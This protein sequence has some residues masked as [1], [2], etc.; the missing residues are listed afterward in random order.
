MNAKARRTT[1]SPQAPSCGKI[2]PANAQPTLTGKALEEFDHAF[3]RITAPVAAERLWDRVLTDRQRSR[4][5]RDVKHAYG[6]HQGIIGMWLALNRVTPQ[7]AT[8]DCALA[9]NFLDNPTHAWLRREIGKPVEAILHSDIP[10]WNKETGKL[11]F[12]GKRIRKVRVMAR[13]S[14]IQKILDKFESVSWAQGIDNPLNV[15]DPQQLHQ[16]VWSL[17][18]GLKRIKFRV[19]QGGQKLS[20]EVR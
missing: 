14:N 3:L 16:A 9:L 8:L 10:V 18:S 2:A 19:I 4:L 11:M 15:R 5:G 6:K 17:N 12:K 7:Q 13:P 20:W 1:T